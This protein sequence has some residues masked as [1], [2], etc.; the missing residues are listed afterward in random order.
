MNLSIIGCECKPK[1]IQIYFYMA[2]AKKENEVCLVKKKES[3]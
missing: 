1:G 3:L 2:I